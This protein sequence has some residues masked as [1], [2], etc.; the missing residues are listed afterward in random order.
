MTVEN[1]NISLI[2]TVVLFSYNYT[3]VFRS[4]ADFL[5]SA[6]GNVHSFYDYPPTRTDT[7]ET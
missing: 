5:L 1:I 3:W 7:T 2:M 6:R 4:A